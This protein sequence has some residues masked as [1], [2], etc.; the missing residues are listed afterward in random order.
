MTSL[1]GL[2]SVN[3]NK[4]SQLLNTLIFLVVS[5]GVANANISDDGE[6]ESSSTK[7]QPC[8]KTHYTVDEYKTVKDRI[9]KKEGNKTFKITSPSFMNTV[10]KVKSKVEST[11]FSV[12]ETI[13]K[14]KTIEVL[15]Q[16][17]RVDLQIKPVEFETVIEK[18][19]IKEAY[20]KYVII[21][22]TYKTI[23]EEL[24]VKEAYT[25]LEVVPA[26]YK[27]A[28]EEVL[29]KEG[30][31]KLEFVPP[32]YLSETESVKTADAYTLTVL[33]SPKFEST[34]SKYISK[35]KGSHW[36]VK[37]LAD[38]R[39]ISGDDCKTTCLVLDPAKTSIIKKLIVKRPAKLLSFKKPAIYTDVTVQKLSADGKV[40]RTP[41]KPEYKMLSKKVLLKEAHLNKIYVPAEY[42]T[43]QVKVI[44]QPAQVKIIEVPAVYEDI[45]KTIIK[46]SES[47]VK[48]PVKKVMQSVT[49]Q[50]ID[51]E[52][53]S[54]KEVQAAEYIDIATKTLINDS[55]SST[56]EI[57]PLYQEI[58]KSILVK[59]GGVLIKEEVDCEERN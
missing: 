12:T 53:T 2:R 23:T 52:S 9:L 56:I 15:A 50:V 21:P 37:P 8:Y 1:Y 29:M 16:E 35:E 32:R 24:K 57:K 30:S 46:T 11:T 4:S 33:S 6:G 26:Q 48:I 58:E 14:A 18:V 47:F 28:Q 49:I 43:I 13:Y 59:K 51:K 44:D 38:C 34:N 22:E 54:T 41:I 17:E 31:H 42:N 36:Q 7:N 3:M 55:F 5:S 20:Q 40:L 19:L 39:S 25:K 27:L 10:K 45:T